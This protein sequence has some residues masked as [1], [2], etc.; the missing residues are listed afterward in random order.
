MTE[1]RTFLQS[2]LCDRLGKLVFTH[3][4]VWK[5]RRERACFGQAPLT[6]WGYFVVNCH[7]SLRYFRPDNYSC[8]Q[9]EKL[10]ISADLA[11][12]NNVCLLLPVKQRVLPE[13]TADLEG[14]AIYNI[15]RY[16]MICQS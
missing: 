12:L 1:E 3:C 7:S 11:T 13:G 8:C 15:F 10:P 16:T 9:R 6:G 14:K 4:Q 5:V 2:S